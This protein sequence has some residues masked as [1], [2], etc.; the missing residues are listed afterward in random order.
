[1]EGSW[2]Q[3]LL[4]GGAAGAAGG[5]ASAIT[6]WIVVE[7][8]LAKAVALEGAGEDTHGHGH[9]EAAHAHSHDTGEAGEV[10]TRLQQ[11]VG[12]V[13]TV[14]VVAILM[15]VAFSVVYARSRH[16]LPGATDLGR[17]LALGFLAFAVMGLGPALAIPAN[18]PG[19]GDPDTVNYR[20]LCYLLIIALGVLLV[21][22]SF[23]MRRHLALREVAA[24]TAWLLVAVMAVA[25]AAAILWLA[26][27]PADIVPASMPAALLWEFRI[28][29]LAQ[30][31]AAWGVTGLVHGVLVQRAATL[32]SQPAASQVVRA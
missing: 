20:T 14:L 10:V 19:V 23:G 4:R 17:S 21:G 29:S 16:R 32:R 9:G 22:A 12:G 11:Q 24:G 26:P 30:L 2:A 31:A 15:G 13:I 5:I 25:G 28:G 6:L 18:P 1:M 7:P 3:R 27:G 8:V